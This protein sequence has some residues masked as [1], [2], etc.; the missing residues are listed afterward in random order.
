[1]SAAKKV[2][3]GENRAISVLTFEEDGDKLHLGAVFLVPTQYD[4]RE[5]KTYYKP[6]GVKC[7][8][9]PEQRDQIIILL[10]GIPPC[11]T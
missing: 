7:P 6:V 4:K 5:D 10:G 2:D 9:T 3:L 8:I 11:R 1:M